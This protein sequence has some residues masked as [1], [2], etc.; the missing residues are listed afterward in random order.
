MSFVITANTLGIQVEQKFIPLTDYLSNQSHPIYVYD[1]EQILNRCQSYSNAMG[2][3]SEL[4]YAIKANSNPMILKSI[5]QKQWGADVVSGG[6]LERALQCGCKPERVV[7]SGVGKSTSEIRFAVGSQIGQINVESLPELLR[8]AQ[9]TKEMNKTI[10]VALRLNPNVKADTHPYITTG[11]T[12]NKFGL[13]LDQ[14]PQALEILKKNPQVTLIGLACHIGSQM[15]DLEPVL[16]SVKKLHEVFEQLN[17]EAWNLT[18]LDIGGG[19]G[20]DYHQEDLGQDELR[21]A[22]FGSGIGQLLSNFK[23]KILVE[24]G[25]FIVARAGVLLTQVEYVKETP[26]RTFV[27]LNSG[28]NHLMRPA[29]YQSFHRVHPVITHPERGQMVCD[30]VGPICESS[31]VLRTDCLL[32][33]IKSGEWLAIMDAGAYG[34]SMANNYNLCG[35][36]KEWIFTKNGLVNLN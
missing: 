14:I 2:E 9:V 22:H 29:L 8:V 30:I 15:L 24:P 20:I 32:P 19:I 36:P 13:D 3:Y 16:Q 5:F 7:F 35:L 1:L 31:D 17:R 4:R 26:H 34:F 33:K 12:K 25:R 18:T 23:G 27:I 10:S 6:E 28:M 11:T 21:L